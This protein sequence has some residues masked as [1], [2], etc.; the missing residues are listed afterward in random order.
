MDQ[1][2][3]IR[4]R[5]MPVS[6]KQFVDLV[7][8]FK[9]TA[10]SFFGTSCVLEIR[11]MDRPRVFSTFMLPDDIQE[12][13]ERRNDSHTFL[14]TSSLTALTS[15][16]W[17]NARYVDVT[18]RPEDQ[19]KAPDYAFGHAEFKGQYPRQATF[20]IQ[21]GG[22]TENEGPKDA[23][24]ANQRGKIITGGWEMHGDRKFDRAP[25]GLF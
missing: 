7:S 19:A 1:R 10:E 3:G 5:I 9:Q 11:A 22:K 6:H 8:Q 16:I 21:A 25:G 17:K 18:V 2:W 24:V 13:F 12:D 14:K 23:F 4:N 15:E 20:Y